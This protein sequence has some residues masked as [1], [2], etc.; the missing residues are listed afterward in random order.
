MSRTPQTKIY[1]TTDPERI[2]RWCNEG[3][4]QR[5]HFRDYGGLMEDWYDHPEHV[6]SMAIA[7]VNNR[8]IGIAMIIDYYDEGYVDVEDFGDVNI[9]VYVKFNYRQYG[10]GKALV[11]RIRKRTDCQIHPGKHNRAANALYK[12]IKQL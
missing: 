6:E 1:S 4:Q 9:G 3:L 5:V 12:N 7:T 8:V 11:Q 2:K 10:I